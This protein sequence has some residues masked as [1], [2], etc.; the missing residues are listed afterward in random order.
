M[1]APSLCDFCSHYIKSGKCK[2]FPD[3][4]GIPREFFDLEPHFDI[5]PLQ[6]NDILFEMNVEKVENSPHTRDIRLLKN[7]IDT[8]ND[9]HHN[10]KPYVRFNET[11]KQ[12]IYPKQEKISPLP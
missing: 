12:M 10:G 9:K 4:D 1:I 11:T 8:Y 5:H 2:A 7:S 3:G 6:K